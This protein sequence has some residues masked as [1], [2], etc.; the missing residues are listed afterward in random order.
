LVGILLLVCAKVKGT[1][2][3]YRAM[4]KFS[5]LQM[6]SSNSPIKKGV[7][8]YRETDLRVHDHAAL[9]MAQKQCSEVSHVFCFNPQEFIYTSL[10]IEKTGVKRLKFLAEC[11]HD[12][13]KRI[14]ALGGKLTTYVGNP[15]IIIPKLFE[16]KDMNHLYFQKNIADY[17]IRQEDMITSSVKSLNSAVNVQSFFGDSLL[18][19]P[20]DLPFPISELQYFTSFRKKVESSCVISDPAP[21][22]THVK[23]DQG[24]LLSITSLHSYVLSDEQ[25]TNIIP[26][27]QRLLNEAGRSSEVSDTS[28]LVELQKEVEMDSRGVLPFEGGETAALARVNHY[29]TN[30]VNRLSIYKETRNGLVGA[31]YSSK[32]SPW[33]ATGCISVKR[34][35]QEVKKFEH[36][37]GIANE[38]TYWLIFELLWRDYMQYYGMKYGSTIFHLGGP[39]QADGVRKHAWGRDVSLFTAWT[40]GRT[41]YPFIDANMRELKLTGFM[42]NRGRQVVGSFLVRDL[43]LDWRLG[44]QHFESKLLDYDVC[45][46][47]GNWQY[48]AGVG[49]D[50][51]EDR[52]FNIIKQARD[53]DPKAEYIRRWCPELASLPTNMLLDPRLLT[54]EVRQRCRVPVE[55]LP[56]PVV[57]LQFGG[58]VA[59]ASAG[60]R[61]GSGGGRG[62]GGNNK[63]RKNR[64]NNHGGVPGRDI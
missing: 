37:T 4:S 3:S 41:G 39:Q 16:T 13:S 47:Y 62:S 56:E 59:G 28:L 11:V 52:Y 51:R 14:H 20:S 1:R 21:T 32:L 54:A 25:L 26:L 53:Y 24:T 5:S 45:S 61:G 58:P 64:R 17:E 10:G 48:V 19:K 36:L 33:L 23:P 7:V 31:D 6:S 38:S 22:V 29:I 42:S 40:E 35:H 43:A 60:P 63:K 49:A 2:F 9:S 27:Y 30:G 15:T 18:I 50:P 12:L 44:A 34:I 57:P 8:W 46:N 55:L